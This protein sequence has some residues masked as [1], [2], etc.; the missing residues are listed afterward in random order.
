MIHF[1]DQMRIQ[2]NVG[3]G[4]HYSETFYFLHTIFSCTHNYILNT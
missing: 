1:I 3:L 2:A 4:A